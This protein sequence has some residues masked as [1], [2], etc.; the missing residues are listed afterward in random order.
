L[1]HQYPYVISYIGQI[2]LC[3]REGCCM[4]QEVKKI[5]S[6]PEQGTQELPKGPVTPLNKESSNKERTD[7]LQ[8]QDLLV[9][10]TDTAWEKTVEK[11]TKPVAVMFY[12]PSC[13]FCRQIE[14]YF[15]NY[16]REFHE[17][18]L[19]G[20]INV[21][22]NLWTAERYGVKGTPTFKFFC[23]G[24]PVFE[25]V[26]AIYPVILKKMIEEVLVHGKECALSSTA[27]DYEIT[28]YG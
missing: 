5:F 13:P 16:A 8:S 27:I 22:T 7:V 14:P 28:G 6:D 3:L 1:F 21:V 19:F 4:G 12:S 25:I 9:E 20:R 10:L 23:G 15:V 11:G 17:N 2:F 24:K 18:I 26:G